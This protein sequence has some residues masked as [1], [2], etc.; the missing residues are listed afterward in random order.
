[1]ENAKEDPEHVHRRQL[2]ERLSKLRRDIDYTQEMV[3][4]QLNK[5]RSAVAQW[6][7]GHT[8]PSH[9]ECIALAR[10]FSTSPA[11]IAF[12]ANEGSTAR[13]IDIV[14]YLPGREAEVIDRLML[15]EQTVLDMGLP[16]SAS[17]RAYRLP[18]DEGKW[19]RGDL[20]IIDESYQEL[21]RSNEHILIAGTA[22]PMMAIVTAS[23]PLKS[24]VFDLIIRGRPV[25]LPRD[26][27]PVIGRIVGSVSLS[28]YRQL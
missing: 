22:V 25:A 7:R 11:F 13:Q 9:T 6:E 2:G 12:G 20:L 27:I 4:S 28:E 21:T 10:L 3:A 19:R 15:P 24:D 17:L 5:S 23:P 1:M 18:F 8:S 26:L 14:N 16:A